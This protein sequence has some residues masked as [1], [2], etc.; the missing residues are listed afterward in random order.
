MD[1]P[2]PYGCDDGGKGGCNGCC[3]GCCVFSSGDG[4][5]RNTARN[6][7]RQ[8][9]RSGLLDD[10]NSESP[11]TSFHSKYNDRDPGVS[12]SR[13]S[14]AALFDLS[15]A[16][17]DHESSSLY[18]DAY[19]RPRSVSP[20]SLGNGPPQV[21]RPSHD[22]QHQHQQHR[23]FDDDDPYQGST[24]HHR[25]HHH[26][27]R[28][29]RKPPPP[30]SVPLA[31]QAQLGK[32]AAF[33]RGPPPPAPTFVASPQPQQQQQ[34]AMML[35]IAPGIKV[36]L[37]GAQETK[38]CIARDFYIPALCYAC[39]LDMFCIMDANY[40]V[41]PVCRVV[42]PLEGGADMEY[43]GGV[44]LGFTFQDLMDW[45]R[46]AREREQQQQRRQLSSQPFT[47]RW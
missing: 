12:T 40:V 16:V 33:D 38:A 41:C 5:G 19:L 34:P 23:H 4:D 1:C 43:E 47:A 37:R 26:H 13:T 29:T 2:F 8:Q 14:V 27:H 20:D 30:S 36:R 22:F 7:R 28:H 44:G 15:A 24:T 25:R 35:Q 42:S 18:T 6:A 46:D 11:P 17:R 32:L 3:N 21:H 45:Q 39:T 9:D 10:H 31:H